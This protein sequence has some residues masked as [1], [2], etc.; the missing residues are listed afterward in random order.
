MQFICY[1]PNLSPVSKFG[2]EL[3][4]FIVLPSQYIKASKWR[5]FQRPALLR[6]SFFVVFILDHSFLF[7]S[8]CLIKFLSC[9][10]YL[11]FF[12][13]LFLACKVLPFFLPPHP[14]PHPPKLI[15]SCP[16]CIF[17]CLSFFI[18][19]APVFFLGPFYS[20]AFVRIS[21]LLFLTFVLS[22]SS[23]VHP[24]FHEKIRTCY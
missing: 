1:N 3:S 11:S 16:P 2:S 23:I 21:N 8:L 14:H 5:L 4:A 9:T 22:F 20:Y 24:L 18:S 12:L 19:P 7:L 13:R 10:S 15:S 17:L 6:S